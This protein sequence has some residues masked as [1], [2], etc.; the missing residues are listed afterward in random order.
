MEYQKLKKEIQG[1]SDWTKFQIVFLIQSIFYPHRGKKICITYLLVSS[2]NKH[3]EPLRPKDKSWY[4]GFDSYTR[5]C[6]KFC[7][8]IILYMDG[9]EVILNDNNSIDDESSISTKPPIVVKDD[10]NRSVAD[11]GRV[12]ETIASRKGNNWLYFA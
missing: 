3:I 10:V 1:F 4:E 12:K 9:T 2:D 8:E 5:A 11:N 6:K 7:E